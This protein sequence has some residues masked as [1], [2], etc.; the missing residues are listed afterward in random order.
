M[1]PMNKVSLG[2]VS[3][4][5]PVLVSGV[6]RSGT[7]FVTA[8]LG[9]H[10]EFRASSSVV[11]FLRFCAGRYGEMSSADN[12]RALVEDTA[13]RIAVRWNLR[14]DT[15]S[16]LDAAERHPHPSYALLYD[17][18]MRQLLCKDGNAEIRWVEKLAVQWESIPDFLDMFPEGRVVHVVRDPRDVTVSY[19]LMTFEAGNTYLDAAFNCRGSM[20]FVAGLDDRYRSRV[21]VV[22]AED[23]AREPQE[24]VERIAAFLGTQA[25][26]DMF[27][28]R[29]LH[30]AGEE[31]VTNTSVSNKIAGW[32]DGSP[33]WPERLSRV[34]VMFVELVTQP[35][36][37]YYGYESSGFCPTAE[38]WTS[39]FQL[40]DDGFL[41]G[42]FEHW[43]TSGRGVQGYRT[44]PYEHEMKIVFPE[45]Y[46]KKS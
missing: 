33:R 9:A 45:R 29:K 10:P 38:E 19:K 26:P 2:S 4:A 16:I 36:L 8:L 5:R 18:I 39:M 24:S 22:R 1:A 32:P 25:H 12:R 15:S 23:L 27:D 35:W 20:E 46:A 44:D 7:T 17:L 40:I 14:L 42:R 6:Y 13:K 30:A 41:R 11:K 34:E 3:G 28:P 37:A 43:L 31:W 21:L